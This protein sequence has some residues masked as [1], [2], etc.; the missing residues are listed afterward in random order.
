M[1]PERD[2]DEIETN[3]DSKQYRNQEREVGHLQPNVEVCG[4]AS[5]SA[6][7]AMR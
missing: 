7:K 1:S 5:P 2:H 3:A 6:D 4:A